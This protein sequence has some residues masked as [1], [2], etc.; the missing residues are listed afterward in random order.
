MKQISFQFRIQIAN[1]CQSGERLSYLNQKNRSMDESL[2]A[3]ILNNEV[4]VICVSKE[5]KEEK[6]EEKSTI[7]AISVPLN[8]ENFEDELEMQVKYGCLVA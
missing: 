6:M 8:G 7:V 3:T 2:L 4:D 5:D 1:E